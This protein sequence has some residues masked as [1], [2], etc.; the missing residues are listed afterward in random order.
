MNIALI[1]EAVCR[2]GLHGGVHLFVVL[3]T[4]NDGRLIARAGYPCGLRHRRCRGVG[5]VTDRFCFLMA[6]SAITI[7]KPRRYGADNRDSHPVHR[8]PDAGRMPRLEPQMLAGNGDTPESGFFCQESSRAGSASIARAWVLAPFKI[9]PEL[10][11]P[12]CQNAEKSFKRPCADAE[13]PQL[14]AATIRTAGSSRT[15]ERW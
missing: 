10:P 3:I 13:S 7:L 11:A 9:K 2:V 1:R 5:C 8:S 15:R 12:A 6:A 14:P 4:R